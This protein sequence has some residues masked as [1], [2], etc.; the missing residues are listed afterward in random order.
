[1][2]DQVLSNRPI[3]SGSS[4]GL[5]DSVDHNAQR[6]DNPILNALLT[7]HRSF[8]LSEGPARRYP[9]AIGPLSGMPD[10]SPASYEALR[11]LAGPGGVVVLFLDE[12]PSP[13]AGWTL[14]RGGVLVQMICL[15]STAQTQTCPTSSAPA[16]RRLTPADVPAMV[17]LATLTEP[18]PFRE[19]TAEIGLFFGIF[20]GERLLAMAGQR[21]HLP[22]F[23]EVSAVCTH[24]EARG[25]GYA[26]ILIEAV[27]ADIRERREIPIL[28]SFA[29]NYP[30]I[31]VYQSLDFTPRRKFHL[32]VLKNEAHA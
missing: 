19:R 26:R 28:H 13:P 27:S 1:M 6:L 29:D 24:P 3:D 2:P 10:Q 9:A 21:L 23:I 7:E 16:I 5:Q 17:E 32:A 20:A 31:R 11:K 22:G 14:V 25:R 30:A 12:P 4:H 18:G 15:Q 8:A